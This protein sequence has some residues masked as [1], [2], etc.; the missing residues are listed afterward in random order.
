MAWIH[1]VS[2]AEATGTVREIYDEIKAELGRISP[3][4]QAMSLRPDVLRLVHDLGNAI[5]F[6]GSTLGRKR[7]QILAV[8]VSATNR[9]RY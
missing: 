2:E 7:E 6:G 1:V 4:L 8:V 5:H 3:M 9:C